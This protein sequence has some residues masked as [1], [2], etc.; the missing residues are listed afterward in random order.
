MDKEAVSYEATGEIMIINPTDVKSERFSVREFILDMPGDTQSQYVT[1]QLINH[2]C[3]LLDAFVPGDEVSVKFKL[4]GRKWDG[5]RDGNLRY[6]NSLN[7]DQIQ[8]LSA[9][10]TSEVQ[11]PAPAP[12]STSPG[13]D[14][15]F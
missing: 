15:P 1:F 8:R 14:V 3:A 12:A 11:A 13:D 4:S 6:F 10:P 5:A 9:A 2:R 7:V